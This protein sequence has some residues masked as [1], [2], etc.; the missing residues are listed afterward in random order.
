MTIF[1]K[2]DRSPAFAR[3]E[4]E[5]AAIHLGRVDN[6]NGNGKDDN[7]HDEHNAS[8]DDNYGNYNDNYGNY[9]VRA[10]MMFFTWEEKAEPPP[11]PA[12]RKLD[13]S[14]QKSHN[15]PFL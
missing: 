4:P 9:D 15:L 13:K 8:Y 3:E 11:P 12:G 1:G 5:D 14:N 10:A 2:R 6:D 7:Y